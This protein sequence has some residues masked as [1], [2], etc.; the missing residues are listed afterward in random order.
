MYIM[1]KNIFRVEID[2]NIGRKVVI[3]NLND[4]IENCYVNK[5]VFSGIMLEI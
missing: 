3:K 2:E 5:E 4:F 1:I